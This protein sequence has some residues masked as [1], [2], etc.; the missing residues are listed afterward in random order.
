MNIN[1]T[2]IQFPS[3][4]HH[5]YFPA[6]TH[7]SD[8]LHTHLRTEHVLMSC[9]SCQVE[10]S[11]LSAMFSGRWEQSLD[12]DSQGHIFLDLDP[13]CFERIITYLRSRS[14]DMALGLDTAEP[15]IE[16]SKQHIYTQLIDYLGLTSVM[17]GTGAALTE[18]AHEPFFLVSWEFQVVNAVVDGA[19]SRMAIA[20][21]RCGQL[22]ID[23]PLT[24][25]S[26]HFRKIKLHQLEAVFAGISGPESV[27]SGQEQVSSQTRLYGWGTKEFSGVWIDGQCTQ[28]PLDGFVALLQSTLLFKIDL[29]KGE[30]ACMAVAAD[31]SPE[32]NAYARM[33]IAKTFAHPIHVYIDVKP[34]I[35]HKSVW[36]KYPSS[37]QTLSVS[38]AEKL[39]FDRAEV[40]AK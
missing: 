25:G 33:T 8:V 6:I 30:L 37:V 10:G 11:V 18:N 7:M 40:F 21:H 2:Y 20:E 24:S 4:R 31:T 35:V 36:G 23:A 3:F 27:T 16:C 1:P 34:H 9:V 38:E 32:L 28:Q 26:V 15:M 12:H 39:L 17:K 14:R 5:P 22:I 19:W 13:Y 29:V